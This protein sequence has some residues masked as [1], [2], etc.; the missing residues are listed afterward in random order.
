M[1]SMHGFRAL[2]IIV[3]LLVIGNL[4]LALASAN[5]PIIKDS[6]LW[7]H[8]LPTHTSIQRELHNNEWVNNSTQHY[9]TPTVVGATVYVCGGTSL[10]A[11][12]AYTGIKLWNTSSYSAQCAPVVVGD[13]VYLASTEGLFAISATYGMKLWNY[14]EL[15]YYDQEADCYQPLY[16]AYFFSAPAVVNGR[17]YA[18]SCDGNLMAFD[19]TTGKKLWNYTL[20]YREETAPW[21]SSLGTPIISNNMIFVSAIDNRTLYALSISDGHPI[22]AFNNAIT[23]PAVTEGAVYVGSTDGIV[24]TLNPPDGTMIWNFT[25]SK[26]KN[27][28]KAV[29]TTP[30]FFNG[31]VYAHSSDGFLFALDGTNGATIWKL[32]I[33]N[34]NTAPTITDGIIYTCNQSTTIYAQNASTGSKITTYNVD[35]APYTPTVYNG[36]MYVGT[37]AGS[38]Y[39]FGWPTQVVTRPL[40]SEQVASKVVST[41]VELIV[42]VSVAGGLVGVWQYRKKL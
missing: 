10:Y 22:W 25:T 3:C 6:I 27:T 35:G 34:S 9:T 12:D 8:T 37:D 15:S 26:D 33:G 42:T 4:A 14:S 7:K 30:L 39:A 29:D 18:A 40:T 16:N 21:Y 19:A 17:V 24:Y 13:T 32:N 31:I 2:A 20:G 1:I 28:G 38:I 36:I 23:E 11:Y 5:S 41:A